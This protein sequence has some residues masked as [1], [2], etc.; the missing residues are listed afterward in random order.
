MYL[1]IILIPLISATCAGL[2]GRYLGSKGAGIFTT[3][4]IGITSLLSWNLFFKVGLGGSPVWLTIA[5]WMESDYLDLSF[6]LCIDSLTVSMLIL[7]TTVSTLVHLYSTGYMSEDPHLPRFMSYLSLFTMFMIILVTADNLVQLFIGWE[8]VGLCSYLLINFWFTRIE[9]NKSAINA[10]VVNRVG[11]LGLTLGIL[12]TFY[13]FG[14]VDLAT[15]FAL[16]PSSKFETT[17]FLNLEINNMTLIGTLF[18][19]GAI[20]KSAQLGLHIWLPQA[21]EGPTPVS[22]LIHSSTMVT[23]GV[24]L[25]I[26]CCP[27]LEMSNQALFFITIIG[28]L[29]AFFAASVAI[30]QNDL[31]KVIAYSTTSQLGYMVFACGLSNYS[32]SIYHLVNHGFFKALLFLCAGSIIHALA[33]EQDLRRMGG[34]IK[35]LPYTYSVMTIGSLSLMGFPFLTGFYSKDLILEVAYAQYSCSGTFA[36]WLGTLSAFLTA[37]YS[38]RLIYLAFISNTNAYKNSFFHVHEGPLNMSIP[39][40]ILALGSIFVGYIGKDAFVGMGT[41]FW[42]NALTFYPSRITILESE[43]MPT[44]IKLIPVIFS[45]L[46]ASLAI[47]SYHF[48]P[49][50][51]F[52]LKTSS[53][54]RPLFFFLSNKWYWEML[55]NKVIVRPLLHFGNIISY[56]LLDRGLFEIL[57]PSGLSRGVISLARSFSLLQSGYIYHYAFILFSATTLSILLITSLSFLSLE[58]LGESVAEVN[59]GLE[60]VKLP[61]L[62]PIMALFYCTFSSPLRGV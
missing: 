37:F 42:N 62:L 9:A 1:S 49:S 17:T 40:G 48:F 4:S 20:G 27:L 52:Y 39:L 10:M 16:A 5:K 47:L 11:D 31:K 29:T 56:K 59:L 28:A 14:A 15:I 19:I 57:G 12:A 24:F 50:F 58:T 61:F 21:M 43:F 53:Y 25:L 51:L 13:T 35:Y 23:A 46:G 18:L 45:L 6:G 22:A 33:D 8:G 54:L 44:K 36:H 34:L 2:F 26:R 41:T 55:Y 60:G 32:V 7:V 30:V 3:T 38:F